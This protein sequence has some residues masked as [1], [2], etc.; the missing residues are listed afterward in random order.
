[1]GNVYL[2]ASES[3]LTLNSISGYFVRIGNT[4]DEIS[5]YRKDANG[6]FIKI[7]DGLNGILNNSNSVMK[8]KV[9]RDETNK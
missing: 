9:T 2:I 1:M 3:N 6:T 7:I 4:D 5:L 8:I